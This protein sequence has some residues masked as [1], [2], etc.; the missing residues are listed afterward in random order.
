[1]KNILKIGLFALSGLPIISSVSFISKDKQDNDNS[2]N[3]N[4]QNDDNIDN[5]NGEDNKEVD[6]SNF[7]R[8]KNIRKQL[9]GN[10]GQLPNFAIKYEYDEFK[11]NQSIFENTFNY[12]LPKDPT[13]QWLN[14]DKIINQFGQNESADKNKIYSVQD[15]YDN[16]ANFAN[17]VIENDDNILG[18]Q[19][20]YQ[21]PINFSDAKPYNI[22][23]VNNV[24]NIFNTFNNFN[25]KRSINAR[26]Q[27][28]IV[29]LHG[30]P[31]GD[32]GE[33]AL[34]TPLNTGL[35]G[36]GT[37]FVLNQAQFGFVPNEVVYKNK[38]KYLNSQIKNQKNFKYIEKQILNENLS[39][40]NALRVLVEDLQLSEYE[41]LIATSM[42][43][44]KID[45]DKT[46]LLGEILKNTR[47][48]YD[49]DLGI[50]NVYLAGGSHGFTVG[51]D[52]IL[53]NEFNV[54]IY[55]DFILDKNHL[56][57]A[58]DNSEVVTGGI[59]TKEDENTFV[60]D[61]EPL[62]ATFDLSRGIFKYIWGQLDYFDYKLKNYKLGD[63]IKNQF[64]AL[65]TANDL[66]VG[67]PTVQ[68][69]NFYKDNKLD[70]IY[71]QASKDG[72]RNEFSFSELNKIF[73]K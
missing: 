29:Y 68:E 73:Y 27:N 57:P 22:I 63:R 13:S 52:A 7:A 20:W 61:R 1:M 46:A 56:S 8:D 25:K 67:N 62:D 38:D 59:M 50:D 60:G 10:D 45:A 54:D 55:N 6:L 44:S 28:A 43:F 30:G 37:A 69:I 48:G 58:Q 64:H 41:T 40:I 24:S 49:Y 42:A 2:N 19:S 66:N 39:Q 51:V 31:E 72:H 16:A 4:A 53:F 71:D 34:F 23:S 33:Y 26:K 3:I 47:P 14:D 17:T 32:I 18:W 15:L 70:F 35:D 36:Y 5:N 12:F 11:Y 21:E 65:V 9:S